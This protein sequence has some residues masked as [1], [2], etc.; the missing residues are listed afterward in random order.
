MMS[1]SASTSFTNLET[2]YES[3]N[4]LHK[5]E[6]VYLFLC[7]LNVNNNIQFGRFVVSKYS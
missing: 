2:K 4:F 6:F 3:T 5:T 7:V 1:S